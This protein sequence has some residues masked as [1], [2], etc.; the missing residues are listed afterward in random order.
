LFSITPP[1]PEIRAVLKNNMEEY[2]WAVQTANYSIIQRMRFAFRITKARTP[3]IHSECFILITFA[4]Q[5]W[6]RERAS[7]L[8]CM[9]IGCLVNVCIYFVR[10]QCSNL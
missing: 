4:R 10:N 8:R 9:C 3:D 5:Q 1:P 6:L 2:G 7:V